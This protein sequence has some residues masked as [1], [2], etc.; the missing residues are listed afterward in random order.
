[1]GRLTL[2]VLLSFAQFEREVTGERIRDKF[3]T[4]CRSRDA[5]PNQQHG[6]FPCKPDITPLPHSRNRR[7]SHRRSARESG[8]HHRK[9]DPRRLGLVV[10]ISSAQI[11]SVSKSE[12]VFRV[13]YDVVDATSK[14]NWIPLPVPNARTPFGEHAVHVALVLPP[15]TIPV[16]DAFPSLNWQDQSHGEAT[17]SNVPSLAMIGWKPAGSVRFA[18]RVLTSSVLTDAG[19]LTILL[20]GSLIWWFRWRSEARI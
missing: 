12:L 15:G 17:L 16:G 18:D 13:E 14:I 1:M 20:A 6:A 4:S 11:P 3:A 2:N 8:G 10:S 19:M 7:P 5:Y 9:F